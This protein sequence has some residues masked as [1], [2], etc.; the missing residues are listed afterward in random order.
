MIKNNRTDD[1]T[2]IINN[3]EKLIVCFEKEYLNELQVKWVENIIHKEGK[4]KR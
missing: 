2:K 4:R 3:K 1:I